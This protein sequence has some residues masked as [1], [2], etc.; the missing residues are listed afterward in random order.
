[1]SVALASQ[2]IGFI[3]F[4]IT[5]MTLLGVYRD[6]ISTLRTAPSSIPVAL[7]NLRQEIEAERLFLQYRL[8]QEADPYSVFPRSR[9]KHRRRKRRE[10]AQLLSLTISDLWME[11]KNLERPFLIR[12]PRRAEEVQRGDF[13]G[14]SDLDDHDDDERSRAKRGRD[15]DVEKPPLN[16][17]EKKI[18]NRMGMAEAGLSSDQT[19]YYNTDLVHRF[20]WWQSKGSV[21]NMLQQ[22]QRI[23]IRRIE[24]DA[25]E[26]DE[27]VKRCLKVL[28]TRGGGRSGSRGGGGSSGSGSD[29]RGGSDGNGV[30]RRSVQSKN[31]SV[32][33]QSRRRSNA[34]SQFRDVSERRHVVRAARRENGTAVG[35]TEA[36]NTV[37][38]RERTPGPRYEYEVV[39]PGRI[40]IDTEDRWERRYR[41]R[42]Q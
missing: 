16:V 4:F 29:G 35:D 10:V 28:S 15:R 22:V 37:R 19:R 3:S 9:R 18:N 6:L 8:Q 17:D 7:G 12:H 32:R 30:R 20:I 40:S 1:M 38:P 34:R 31:G 5:L 21:E 14:E 25:F 39:Q 23:Q 33:V 13:W 36:S 26:T 27:L 11:F 42:E 41:G 24:R 2:V